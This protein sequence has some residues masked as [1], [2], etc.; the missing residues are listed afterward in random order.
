MYR[1]T[2]S[3]HNKV[4]RTKIITSTVGVVVVASLGGG[5]LYSQDLQKPL[6]NT[7]RASAPT[8]AVPI[9]SGAVVSPQPL[10]SIS[11]ASN[12]TSL[13]PTSSG[14][15]GVE[16][17]SSGSSTNADKYDLIESANGQSGITRVIP[18]NING[19]Q[20]VAFDS[21]GSY[22]YVLS[23]PVSQTQ[24][25]QPATTSSS[26]ST[27]STPSVTLTQVSL[28][29]GQTQTSS[30]FDLNPKTIQNP[31]Y[32]GGNIYLGGQ[33]ASGSNAG[34]WVMGVIDPSNLSIKTD[35]VLPG[36][37]IN[38]Q[39]IAT[40]EYAT[41]SVPSNFGQSYRLISIS[42][43]TATV[44]SNNQVPLGFTPSS[45]AGGLVWGLEQSTGQ[46]LGVDPA[47]GSVATR[48]ILTSS[49]KFTPVYAVSSSGNTVY[50]LA[51]S[52]G[53]PS[54]QSVVLY[55]IN[56]LDGSVLTQELLSGL[57]PNAGPGEVVV[58]NNLILINGANALH[59]LTDN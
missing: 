35:I 14:T 20:G 22:A 41:V 17:S 8:P 16:Q 15:W 40:N 59:V 4:I 13:T 30:T 5:Y 39:S 34:K 42:S 51:S 31:T 1:K 47:T 38:S 7:A 3:Q 52:V 21:S 11:T 25:A 57:H 56:A 55:K 46:L 24:S 27:T 33:V 2:S 19:F 48:D 18:L 50:A 49:G 29:T 26:S 45:F 44:T 28:S 12:V 36:T 6:T 58:S 53:S 54:T 23:L 9:S 10:A 32:G 37:L 43:S